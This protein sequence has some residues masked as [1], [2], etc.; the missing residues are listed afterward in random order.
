[1]TEGFRLLKD[2][3]P[4]AKNVK[5][6][7]T[8]ADGDTRRGRVYHYSNNGQVNDSPILEFTGNLRMQVDQNAQIQ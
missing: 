3:G 4:R 7:F 6:C 5:M 2:G 1:M 8:F